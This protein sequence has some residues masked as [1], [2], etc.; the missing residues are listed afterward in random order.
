MLQYEGAVIAHTVETFNRITNY[1]KKYCLVNLSET[2]SGHNITLS[3]PVLWQKYTY[4]QK[5]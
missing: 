1:Y 3:K 4:A 2:L 5:K